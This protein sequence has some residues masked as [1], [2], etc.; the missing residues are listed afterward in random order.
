MRE[1]QVSARIWSDSMHR[2]H[3]WFLLQRGICRAR[4]VPGRHGFKCERRVKCRIMRSCT[5]WLLG[6]HGFN[7]SDGMRARYNLI[8]WSILVYS[9]WHW[10]EHK[11]RCWRCRVLAVCSWVAFGYFGTR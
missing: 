7:R 3:P 4:P 11:R 10:R 9:M 8:E 5:S 6:A 1:W 2:L